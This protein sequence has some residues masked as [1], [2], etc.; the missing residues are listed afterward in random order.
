V[1]A[2]RDPSLRTKLRAVIM[3]TV[4]A[5]LGLASGGFVVYDGVSYREFMGQRLAELA[6]V[7]ATKASVAVAAH[8]A[9]TAEHLLASQ[10]RD[11][12][13]LCAAIYDERGDLLAKYLR[14]E[15]AAGD[16]PLRQPA[17]GRRLEGGHVIVSQP[18][19]SKDGTRIGSLY[20]RSDLPGAAAR[21]GTHAAVMAAI[22]LVSTGLAFLLSSR[23]ERIVTRPIVRL[24]STVN[25]VTTERDYSLRAEKH[26]SD[27]LGVLIDGLNDMLSQ[28]QVRDGALQLARN[29]LELRVEERTAQLSY[30][31]EELK[32]EISERKRAEDSMR[33]SEE[34]YRQLVELSPDAIV[35]HAEGRFVYVNSAAVALLGASS[36][37]QLVGRPVLDF[38]HPDHRTEVAAQIG[39]VYEGSSSILP[40]E[41][42]YLRINGTPI[43]TEV[44][45]IS[46]TF[47]GRPAAQ[48]ILRDITQRKEIE[49]MKN[50]F[51][52]T[53]SH[54]LRTPITSIQG[55]LGL[56][57][58]G[59]MGVLPAAA[60]PL[61]DIAYKNCQRLVLLINDILDM[62]KIAAGQ[63]KF[64]FKPVEIGSLIEQTIEANRSY[65]AQFG[66][67]FELRHPSPGL[68]VDADHDRLIQVFTNL[69]SN[70]AKFSPRGGTVDV[71]VTRRDGG[72]RV[73][74]TD[75]GPGIPEEFR[76]RIFQKF[77]Q[78]DSSDMRQ[79]GG[80]GLGL[81]ICKSIVEKH[82]G[83]IS[84]ETEL[85]RGS[86]FTVD[87]PLQAES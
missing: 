10:S 57:S 9:E 33:E 26:A 59:V 32:Y 64:T 66:V 7:A 77:S 18:V 25:Q 87:L 1:R 45:A 43:D 4:L 40:V 44:A 6:D 81:A 55:S 78:A 67:A 49:R 82:G 30:L 12:S 19:A 69:L 51:V 65:G 62:E 35:I 74:V 56:I 53:V 36:P 11:G 5:C 76:K 84:F 60:K 34:R 21:L 15:A 22:L 14:S 17:D 8:D 83:R 71:D 42:T 73:S 29:E 61:V 16:I 63:M 85:G 3:A 37:S 75:H 70:A 80:T 13:V 72:V 38:V 52:S 2:L 68:L 48:A 28:I 50:E 24:A 58:N 23:V 39:K 86:I 47:Q 79:K 54:E 46:F 20:L 41:R 31:N 27:E